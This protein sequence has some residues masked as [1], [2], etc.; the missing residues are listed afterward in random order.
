MV[1][2][3]GWLVGSSSA[4]ACAETHLRCWGWG[5]KSES[6]IGYSDKLD[7]KLTVL[8]ASCILVP[9]ARVEVQVGA[10]A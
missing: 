5:L 9:T 10:A 1:R 3:T 2:G 4:Y 6:E 8:Y 7:R